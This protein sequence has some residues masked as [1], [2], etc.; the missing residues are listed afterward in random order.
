MKRLNILILP[1]ALL[2][3]GTP[4][5][6]AGTV[7]LKNGQEVEGKIIEVNDKYVVVTFKNGT[8]E[9]E[10]RQILSVEVAEG[11]P[12]RQTSAGTAQKV[13][14]ATPATTAASEAARM[15]QAAEAAKNDAVS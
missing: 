11:D 9:I 2:L 1:A 15:K 6:N 4:P 13:E 12:V 8:L 10:R 14:A 5:A 3:L 7:Y